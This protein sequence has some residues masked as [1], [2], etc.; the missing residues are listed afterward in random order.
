VRGVEGSESDVK[1]GENN[2]ELLNFSISP[3]T[4]QINK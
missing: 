3:N 2:E 4:I 1:T